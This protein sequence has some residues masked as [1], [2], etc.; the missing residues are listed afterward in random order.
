MSQSGWSKVDI[1]MTHTRRKK[2]AAKARKKVLRK[3]KVLLKRVGAHALKHRNLLDVRFKETRFSRARADQVIGRIDEQLAL[4][5]EVIEQAHQRIIAGRL[6]KN[7]KKIL[8]VY[9]REIDVIVRGKAGAQVEFGNEL[10]IAESSGGLIIDYMLYGKRA[11]WEGD[12][13]IESVQRQESLGRRQ[14]LEWAVADWGFDGAATRKA[15]QREGV[16][17]HICPK[18]PEELEVRLKEPDFCRWQ[19]RRASTEARIAIVKNHGCGRVWR[20]K[21]LKNRKVAVGWSV[22]AHNLAWIG[23]KVRMERLAAQAKAA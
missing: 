5:P 15:L 3:M 23:R 21:G 6:V 13:L 18:S 1:E 16:S 4:L 11:P 9:E 20:A 8:S 10:F 12:K 17:S 2:G 22:L 14:D 7:H 19:T